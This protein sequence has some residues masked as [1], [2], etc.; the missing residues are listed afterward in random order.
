MLCKNYI[1]N[2]T[3]VITLNDTVADALL[4][5]EQTAHTD[6]FIVEDNDK[7]FGLVNAEDLLSQPVDKPIK[8]LEEFVIKTSVKDAQHIFS[9]FQIMHQVKVNIVPVVNAEFEFLGEIVQET[10]LD[11]MASYLGLHE[12]HGGMIVL[13]VNPIH[14]SI[15][16]IIQ[17]VQSSNADIMQ[18]NTRRDEANGN[19]IVSL[20]VNKPDIS[21]IVST[22]QRYE[23]NVLHYFG[24]EAYDNELKANYDLLMKYID[25]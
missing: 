17:I 18:L 9:A 19:I 15:G 7:F 10:M 24:E 5:K 1:T 23:Y 4:Q 14:Y 3:P 21:L 11:V 20:I 12:A 6:Y 25:I 8:D 22:L 13:E 16:E 2:E